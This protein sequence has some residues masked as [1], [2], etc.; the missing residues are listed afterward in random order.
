MNRAKKIALISPL[1]V[2]LFGGAV[3]GLVRAGSST[4]G[5]GE[6]PVVGLAGVGSPVAEGR[7]TSAIVGDKIVTLEGERNR[8]VYLPAG[9]G[10]GVLRHVAS[11]PRAGT[12]YV[13]DKQGRDTLIVVSPQGS[14]E[15]SASAEV[16][17]PALS[18]SGDLVWAEDFRVLKMSSP[19][20]QAAKTI[21]PPQGSTAIFSPVFTGPN[22]LIALVQEAVE[23]DTGED[24]SLNNLFRYDIGS[25]TWTRLTAF[26]ATSENW[27]VLRTP[28][29]SQ[30]GSLFFVRLQG[31][32]S[33]TRSPSF[34]L[35]SLRGDRTSKVRDLPKEMFL[36]GVN[37]QGLL[38]NIYDGSD[39][40][41]FADTQTGLVD[42]GCGS[43]MVDPRAQPDPDIRK[44]D[45]ALDRRS[46]LEIGAAVGS[47]TSL[48]SA[49]MAVLVGDFSSR[50]GA[51]A[52]A[53]K[54][55]VPKLEIVTHRIAPLAI[56]PGMWGVAK[57]IPADA[58]LSLAMDEF[59]RLF[60]EYA[61]RSWI[62]SLSGGTS[63]G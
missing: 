52:V 38:W 10:N 6:E 60:P 11:A 54:L 57:R 34:E 13:N 22:E 41:L 7:G 15:I 45:P 39:W 2:A 35:W 48:A 43:V 29:F 33:Q 36:A 12:A 17:H 21:A 53:S 63:L 3:F 47:S 14:S 44:E 59:R 31:A 18:A 40:R 26:Q 5:C 16:T 32:A 50:Q 1:A 24:D 62:V 4:A 8:S 25:E 55:G 37:E 28:V 42:L 9:A 20:S 58:D 61:E 19:G 51:E 56:A 46:A 23:G 30:D 49:D 27:S